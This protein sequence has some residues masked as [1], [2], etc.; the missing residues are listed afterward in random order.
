MLSA[1]VCAYTCACGCGWM[2]ECLHASGVCW[3]ETSSH[4]VWP[5]QCVKGVML[6]GLL[7]IAAS[8][9]H[10]ALVLA[11]STCVVCIRADWVNSAA[12]HGMH[13]NA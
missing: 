13:N 5:D 2:H 1:R 7:I 11:A 6:L 9:Q 10:T 12:L 3:A 8:L 4:Y